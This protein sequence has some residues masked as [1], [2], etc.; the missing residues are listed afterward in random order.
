MVQAIDGARSAPILFPGETGREIDGVWLSTEVIVTIMERV[1]HFRTFWILALVAILV[2]A[3]AP[4]TLAAWQCEG[5]T[6]GT[7][8]WVCCCVAT[9]SQQDENCG[10]QPLA[11]KVKA[12]GGIGCASDCNCVLTVKSAENGRLSALAMPHLTV[13]TA[14]VQPQVCL[15]P[16]PLPNEVV[17]RSSEDRG[18]PPPKVCLAS[19]VLRGPPALTF[20]PIGS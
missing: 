17:A 9:A 13:Q 20:S 1:R 11:V 7:S 16:E 12:A 5:R 3:L 14:V 18:P 2:A 15:F 6:C 19:P 4:Q 8:L 10:G